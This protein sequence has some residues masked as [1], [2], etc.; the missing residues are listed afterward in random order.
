MDSH[1]SFSQEA[2]DRDH[3]SS[4][5]APASAAHD[6]RSSAGLPSLCLRLLSAAAASSESGA[7]DRDPASAASHFCLACWQAA[8]APTVR[9]DRPGLDSV[10]IR[11]QS[12]LSK[13]LSKS[14]KTL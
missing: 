2:A 10:E 4:S 3:H 14:W 5:P 12:R 7:P 6:V 9:R 11:V 8:N 1:R 13:C